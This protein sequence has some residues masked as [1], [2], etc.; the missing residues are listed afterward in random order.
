MRAFFLLCA[1]VAMVVAAGG[2][3]RADYM[4]PGSYSNTIAVGGSVTF[5]KTVTVTAGTP[6]A[7]QGD[8]FFLC[9]TTGSMGTP[10]SSVRTN[11]SAIL[12]GLSAYGNIATGAGSY[13]DFPT[14]PWGSSGDYAYRLDAGVSTTAATTQA[15]INTWVAGGGNDTPESEL[16]A[17][18]QAATSG[19]TGWRTGSEKFVLWFGDAPGHE[20]SNTAGYPGPSTAQT[21]SALTSAGITVYAFDVTAYPTYQTLDDYGQASAITS[22]TGGALT[23][24]FGSD[25]VSTIVSA[26][27]TG[28]DTYSTVGIDAPSLSGLGISIVPTGYTGSY[29]R[30]VDRTFT[31]DVTF[32]GLAPGTYDFS[33]YGTVDGGYVA[34]E[35]DHIT[36][37]GVPEPATLLFL[38]FGLLGV[39]GLRRLRRK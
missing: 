14:S 5:T 33:L 15:G 18:T 7:A 2:T 25:V 23:T 9:D 24:G 30:S 35:F 1:V 37:T 29:D 8:V 39:A 36:V 32:T 21:I 26:I 31:F 3:A 19:S 6:T 16:Y 20:P 38:G 27:G 4:T 12:T 34:T 11:A 22:A 13:R 10:I 17:L 28:F